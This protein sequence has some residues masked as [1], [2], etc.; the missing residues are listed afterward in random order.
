MGV[1]RLF[2]AMLATL[3]WLSA[4][5]AGVSDD[6]VTVDYRN[7]IYT[8]RLSARIVVPP[9]VA[10]AVLTDFDRM[11]AFMPGL[12]HSQVVERN[13][14]V[15]RIV[16]RGKA[17][18]GPFSQNYESE[19]RIEVVDASRILSRSLA[20]SAR[21]MES[22]MRIHAADGGTRLD[23]RLE[24][25]PEVWLPSSLAS[26]FL[27]HELAEQFNALGNEMLRRAS[28]QAAKSDKAIPNSP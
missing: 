12:T 13:G 16:Q 22:E 3:P 25:E 28:G 7:G 4:A 8:A 26:N 11:A 1:M 24:L 19:R 9:T 2:L 20:G 18:F 10:L 5:T 6:D 21:R 23:Y 17:R 27:Q 15:Y 14:N